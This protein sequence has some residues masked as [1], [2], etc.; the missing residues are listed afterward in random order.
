MEKETELLLWT[1]RK[2]LD[3]WFAAFVPIVK[4]GADKSSA[5]HTRDPEPAIVWQADPSQEDKCE[6]EKDPKE[7][8]GCRDFPKRSCVISGEP[9]W[10]GH[11]NLCVLVPAMSF[12][13]Q[14][15]HP[16]HRPINKHSFAEDI[17][18]VHRT[19]L[20]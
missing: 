18:L 12:L 6:R 4:T 15:T 11:L 9:L 5:D 17:A 13:L 10:L 1:D 8:C 2:F 16:L 3:F 7:T 20:T 19:E 14:T